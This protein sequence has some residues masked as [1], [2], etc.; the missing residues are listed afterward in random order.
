MFFMGEKAQLA[1][2]A[3]PDDEEVEERDRPTPGRP[4]TVLGNTSEYGGDLGKTVLG[5]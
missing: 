1:V 4:G 3:L 5:S 2:Q